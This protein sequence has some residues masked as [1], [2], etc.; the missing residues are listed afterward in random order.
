VLEVIG[1]LVLVS[2]AF[3]AAYVLRFEGLGPDY[4]RDLFSAAL[5][6]ILAARY[7]VFLLFGLYSSIWRYVGARDAVR[8]VAA[9]ALSEGVAVALLAISDETAFGTF[10]RSVFVID[11]VICALLIGASR[12]GARALA[13]AVPRLRYRGERR[14]TLIVGAGRGGRSLL[15]ELN[16]QPG[17]KVVG[18]VDDNVR[19]L[20]R[21]LQGVPVL[22]TAAD[23]ERILARC[24]PDTV[25]VT[26]PDAPR[27]R[28]DL[29]LQG[30]ARAGV[31]CAF[32]RRETT[33][34]PAAVLDPVPR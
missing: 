25:V 33:V 7:A 17:E 12:F 11:A 30:C 34:A 27:D 9:V 31:A 4:Q 28:L 19:L 29:V 22:G 15:R 8:I 5:P 26:I 1:D 10:S 3:A 2:A 6:V 13:R 14:R 24:R 21:R 18:F 23:I 32:L 20:R 16:E